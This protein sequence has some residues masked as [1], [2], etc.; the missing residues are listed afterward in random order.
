MAKTPRKQMLE[1]PDL[2]GVDASGG[3]FHIPP[4]EYLME[5][6][7]VTPHKAKSG[8]DSLKW[9]FTGQDGRAKGKKFF[10][11][12]SFG[13]DA[14]WKLKATLIS[15]G[16]DIPDSAF[17]IDPDDIVGRTC[18]GI[19][20]DDEY[21]GKP[22][23]RLSQTE[24]IEE[25]E[26]T[27]GKTSTTKTSGKQSAGNGKA[28]ITYTADEISAMQADELEEL[29]DKHKLNLDLDEHKTTR[30]KAG[31]ITA[32]IEEKGLLA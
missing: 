4:G 23:S 6:T 28:S 19:V 29:N 21:E 15:L 25:A 27:A 17:E 1:I 11:Y 3:S 32:A 2:S 26:A 5:C 24:L 13:E 31:A 18:L 16:A 12:T 14:L 9:E 10:V 8:N 7:A 22:V 20:T 30:K